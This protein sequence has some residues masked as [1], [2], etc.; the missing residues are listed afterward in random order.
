[1]RGE[2]DRERQTNR[3]TETDRQ[4]DRQT[5]RQSAR[6]GIGA[7]KDDAA[8]GR[9][10]LRAAAAVSARPAGSQAAR[11]LTYLLKM[12]EKSRVLR[13]PEVYWWHGG[14]N[15][16]WNDGWNMRCLPAP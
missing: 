7:E 5:D 14:W 1:M 13:S 15:D 2:R 6:Q 10:F 11:V 4:I 8:A 9:H 12:S 3:E 16:G